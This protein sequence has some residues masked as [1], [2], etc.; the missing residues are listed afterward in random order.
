MELTINKV[1]KKYGK[2]VAVDNVSAKLQPGITALLGA[3]G[4]GKTTLM[5]ILVDVL[6][7]DSGTVLW[8]G[9]DIQDSMDD[10][11]SC[12][13]YLPQHMGDYPSFKVDQFLEY[14]GALKGL[15]LEYIKQ[16]TDYLLKELHLEA[17]R[18][19]KIKTLSGGM[20]QRLKI[21]QALLNDPSVLILDEPT[22]G[23]DPKERNQFSMMLSTLSQDKI[24]LLST[25]IVSDIENIANKVL[26]MKDGEFIDYN[27]PEKLLSELNGMVFEKQVT[28]D[29]LN[30]IVN[31]I[32]I[33]N[34]RNNGNNIVIRFIS[35]EIIE[36]ACEVTPT[37]S[38]L[39]LYHFKGVSE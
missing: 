13:G 10:Y 39:Y 15:K 35:E 16:R 12:L 7:A 31:R 38:D 24:I 32:I 28:I 2:K 11:L 9:K 19:K 14:M 37:L 33:C 6:K 25:H 26:L 36:G 3:N 8:N 1:N 20:K 22:V 30:K 4:S 17:Q 5:R 34:Q 21:A 23:L 18:K 29:E 27:H